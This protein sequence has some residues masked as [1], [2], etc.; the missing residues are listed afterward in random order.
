MIRFRVVSAR[1]HGLRDA[2]R[3]VQLVLIPSLSVRW[4]RVGRIRHVGIGCAWLNMSWRAG[5]SW[6][7]WEDA[8]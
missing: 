2:K 8:A 1:L 6:A 7:R 5:V 3:G 4:W